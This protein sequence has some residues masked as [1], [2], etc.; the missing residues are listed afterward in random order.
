MELQRW[1]P[2]SMSDLHLRVSLKRLLN[3]FD[4]CGLNASITSTASQH[5]YQS[6]RVASTMS[7]GIPLC[8]ARLTLLHIPHISACNA[9]HA[10]S[11]LVYPPSQLPA[12]F[13][14]RPPQPAWLSFPLEAPSKL[15]FN[16]PSSSWFRYTKVVASLQVA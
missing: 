1:F 6:L 7:L 13:L 4:K 9:L 14:K 15:S 16:H 11:L 8:L 12:E 10:P 2:P 3:V 5:V